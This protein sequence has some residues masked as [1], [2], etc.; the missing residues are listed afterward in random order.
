MNPRE[1]GELTLSETC[2]LVTSIAAKNR[3]ESGDT[4]PAVIQEKLNKAI[5]DAAVYKSLTLEQKLEIA[6]REIER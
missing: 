1:L 4:D 3:E 5:K 6:R 2:F